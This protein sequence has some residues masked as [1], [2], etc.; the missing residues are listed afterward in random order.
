MLP[1]SPC[2]LSSLKPERTRHLWHLCLHWST[3]SSKQHSGSL[4]PN[5][6][7]YFDKKLNSVEVATQIYDKSPF[8]L[9]FYWPRR[10]ASHVLRC[11]KLCRSP[12][13]EVDDEINRILLTLSKTCDLPSQVTTV[14]ANFHTC[15][16][17]LKGEYQDSRKD[18]LKISFN[19]F[20]RVV[21]AW[22]VTAYSTALRIEHNP[23]NKVRVNKSSLQAKRITYIQ[24]STQ[25]LPKSKQGI[26]WCDN[27]A[28]QNHAIYAS[29][30]DI[31]WELN[32]IERRDKN[33]SATNNN[34]RNF[35]WNETWR[36]FLH[37]NVIRYQVTTL[38]LSR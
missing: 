13:L 31:P 37:S 5:T 19:V 11:T 34:C 27:R 1:E 14:S 21:I 16:W 30:M 23:K 24:K 38:L 10:S 33:E 22:I 3:H 17:R 35:I 6:N 18:F 9:F 20:W 12:F 25:Q 4:S 15:M 32:N 28:E 7:S 2:D 8:C 29:W 36:I 26:G